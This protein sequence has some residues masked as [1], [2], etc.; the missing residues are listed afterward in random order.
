MLWVVLAI[1][2][3]LALGIAA[4]RRYAASSP[5]WTTGIG[6]AGMSAPALAL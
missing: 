6:V 1:A 5:A 2:V 3:S 4:E